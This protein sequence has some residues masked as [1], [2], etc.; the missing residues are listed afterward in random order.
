[1]QSI[2]S[3]E[4]FFQK[5]EEI[6]RDNNFWTVDKSIW[7][8]LTPEDLF[9]PV[10]YYKEKTGYRMTNL[11]ENMD[12]WIDCVPDSLKKAFFNDELLKYKFQHEGNTV[13]HEAV[14]NKSVHKIPRDNIKPEHL[15][16]S[17]SVYTALE[18]MLLGSLDNPEKV[19]TEEIEYLLQGKNFTKKNL[20][21]E[22]NEVI[23]KLLQMLENI[24]E[25]KEFSKTMEIK[26]LSVSTSTSTSIIEKFKDKI[27]ATMHKKRIKLGNPVIEI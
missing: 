10:H 13:L 4:N 24:I 26:N 8:K 2:K 6:I 19:T 15:L 20:M 1:M 12:K 25:N 7:L 27:V 3:L 14:R 23:N 17:N 5:R 11:M 21:K 9:E 22:K 16:I 18:F